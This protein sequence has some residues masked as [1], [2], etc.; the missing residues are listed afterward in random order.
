M[1]DLTIDQKHYGYGDNI[2]R[3]KITYIP[4]PF[5][6]RKKIKI[7]TSPCIDFTGREKYLIDIYNKLRYSSVV[8]LTGNGGLGKTQIALKYIDS[9]RN[10]Y[11]HFA[12]INADSSTSIVKEYAKLLNINEDENTVANMN[13]WAG[14]NKNWMFVYDA[15]D[16]EELKKDLKKYIV[17]EANGKII[18]TS[19]LSNWKDKIDVGI[20]TV[21]EAVDFF[22]KKTRIDDL[23]NATKLCDMLGYYPL[24][25]EQAGTYIKYNDISY[26]SYINLYKEPK[27]KSR[28]LDDEDKQLEEY[29]S[30]IYK[31]WKISIDRIKN[32]ASKD[33]LYILSYFA[34]DAIPQ[35]IFEKGQDI[36]PYSIKND[37]DDKM[38]ASKILR[39]LSDYSLIKITDQNISIHKLLQE[40]IRIYTRDDIEKWC[41]YAVNLLRNIFSFDQNNHE[42]WGVSYILIPH[43]IYIADVAYENNIELVNT[44]YLYDKAGQCFR[45]Q[46]RY[47]EAELLYS[48]A[49]EVY[50]RVLGAIHTDTANSYNNL[51]EIHRLLGRYNKAVPLYN[52]AIEAYEKIY[53]EKHADT[54]KSYNYLAR[55]YYSQGRYKEAEH[56]YVKSMELR[57]SIL[58]K[59]NYDTAMS[60]NDLAGL[61]I[62]QEK[63]KEAESLFI[64]SMQIM[65]KVLE[66]EH[67]D[68]ALLYNNLATLY[69]FQERYEESEPL[70]IT[71]M[72]MW[73]KV[74]GEEH[75]N[76]A[77]SYGNLAQLYRFQG[78]YEE[79]KPLF[80]KAIDIREKILGKE[81]P[82]TAITYNNLAEL[83]KLTRKFKDAEILYIKAI[84]IMEKVLGKEHPSTVISYNNLAE[85]YKI[86][87]RHEEVEDILKN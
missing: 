24:A 1:D 79:A 37:I 51:A 46:G 81:H 35:D 15:V 7:T 52:K 11:E 62:S 85:L 73:E 83:Y 23:E 30:T 67:P 55:V 76:T 54:A 5:N 82:Y 71:A 13:N 26:S 63:Y 18:I 31:T 14:H 58:G 86:E 87:G 2:G 41:G 69:Q 42:T 8:V 53:G 49:V 38:K 47:E 48:N 44:A 57:E 60:Y 34:P 29:H 43:A 59:E 9:Y 61:Y 66:S 32:D 77:I 4:K 36:L 21:N 28:L 84:N 72:K 64:N 50:E 39:R 80:I 56:L 68:I 75:P 27:Y 70:H 25:L 33:A 22:S 16:T 17:N 12:F 65:K 10:N 45:Q 74:L 3:D 19:R 20:F 78:K 6:V 40:V